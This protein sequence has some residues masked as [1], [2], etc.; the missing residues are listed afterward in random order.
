MVVFMNEADMQARGHRARGWS[1]SNR[2]PRMEKR[3]VVG[4]FWAKPHSIPAGSIGAYYPETNPLLP[5]AYHDLKSG[6]P[7]AKSIPVLGS[8]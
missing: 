5:L 4:G 1:R 7:A 2:L 8:P 6:T 3:R